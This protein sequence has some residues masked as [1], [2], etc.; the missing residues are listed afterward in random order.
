MSLLQG[1]S[2]TPG[3]GYLVQIFA[4]LISEAN[5]EPGDDVRCLLHRNALVVCEALDAGNLLDVAQQQKANAS[6]NITG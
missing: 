1:C 3:V 4:F 5:L 2:Q 6:T